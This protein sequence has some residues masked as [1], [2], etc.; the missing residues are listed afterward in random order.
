MNR[1]LPSLETVETVL[2]QERNYFGLTVFISEAGCRVQPGAWP[3]LKR[4]LLAAQGPPRLGGP[5]PRRKTAKVLGLA[6]WSG[7]PAG[8]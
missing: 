6:S 3:P 1:F 8:I 4:D 2:S 7:H 5:I